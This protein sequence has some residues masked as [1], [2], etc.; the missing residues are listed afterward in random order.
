MPKI[1]FTLLL[2]LA[3]LILAC[4]KDDDDVLQ[5]NSGHINLSDLQVGQKVSTSTSPAI[6]ISMIRILILT[7]KQIL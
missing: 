6:I 2:S 3:F 5:P 7:I 1:I 4:N